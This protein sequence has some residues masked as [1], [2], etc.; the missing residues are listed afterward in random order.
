M[1]ICSFWTQNED[2]S[3]QKRQD[4][5][6]QWEKER[7]L[8]LD[9]FQEGEEI[10]VCDTEHIWCKA[11]IKKVFK[12]NGKQ[13]EILVHYGQWNKI[14]DEVINV[15]SQRLAPYGFFSDRTDIPHYRLSQNEDNLRGRIGYG[16]ERERTATYMDSFFAPMPQLEFSFNFSPSLNFQRIAP[17]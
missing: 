15:K 6:L 14:Y 12:E 13:N 9:E 4:E 1:L 7:F 2:P 11:M 16:R 5:N 10:D 3:Y 8:K 17:L